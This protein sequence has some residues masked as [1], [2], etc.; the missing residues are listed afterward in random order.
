MTETTEEIRCG[1]CDDAIAPA[2]A[3][4]VAAIRPQLALVLD[5]M[6][7][8]WRVTGWACPVDLAEARR[9]NVTDLL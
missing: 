6:H 9:A 1:V 5:R 8:Q 7:P 4:P 3:M 2:E